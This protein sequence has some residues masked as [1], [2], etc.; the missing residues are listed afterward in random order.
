M[1]VVLASKSPARLAELRRAGIEP[2]VIP[3]EVD[4]SGV[5]A[6]DCEEL[7]ATLATLKAR[8]VR[9]TLAIDSPT[10]VIGCD[11]MLEFGGRP[12]GKP[13]TASAA[14]Q[15]WL[16]MRGGRGILHTG[17]HVR[18]IDDRG[19][20]AATR[21]ESTEVFFADLS[22]DEIDAYVATGEPA[23]VAGAFTIDG[24]GSA[25]I[26]RLIG[27]H[28]NVSG[29]SL[30]LLRQTLIDLGVEWVSLWNR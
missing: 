22:D 26:T 28:H 24:Y 9:D 20:R 1:R 27:D 21:T 15:R 18:V 11:S 7:V 5:V 2:V 30:P 12:F 14:R 23:K 19:E 4:E 13:G 8:A 25:F 16:M 17:H 10:V 3:S 29:I 6:L